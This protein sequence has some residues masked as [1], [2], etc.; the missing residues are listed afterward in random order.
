MTIGKR[1][2]FTTKGT[3][4]DGSNKKV[5]GSLSKNDHFYLQQAFGMG[6][7]PGSG[8]G[9]VEATGGTMN[10]YVD[11]G[12]GNV[13]RS[14]IFTS[15]GTFKVQ[16]SI[17]Q[18]DYLVVAGGAGGGEGGGG[19]G[20]CR[21]N[22]PGHPKA[23]PIGAFPVTPG[24]YTVTVGAGGQG[25]KSQPGGTSPANPTA[26]WRGGDGGTSEFYRVGTSY[27]N[28]NFIRAVGGG[29]GAGWGQS[30][31]AASGGSG[32]G[33]TSQPSPSPI[34][35]GAGNTPTDPNHPQPQGNNG[36]GNPTTSGGPA[37]A[38][39]GWNAVGGGG[40]N[41]PGEGGD[42]LQCLI[43]GGPGNT[44]ALGAGSPT[45]PDVR[46]GYQFFGGGGA[47]G[48]PARKAGGAGGGGRGASPGMNGED[49]VQ[50]SGGG[51]GGHWSGDYFGG[52]GGSGCVV[53]RYQIAGSA[54]YAKATGGAISWWKNPSSPTEY[55]VVHSFFNSG[56]FSTPGSFNETCEYVIVG[57]GGGGGVAALGDRGGGGGGAGGYRTG[58]TPVGSSLNLTVTIGGGGGQT[59]AV[60]ST[61]GNPRQG[62]EGRPGGDSS[63]NWP[64]GTI[65]CP[66]GGG[67]GGGYGAQN[68]FQGA[69]GGGGRNSGLGGAASPNSDPDRFGYPGGPSAVKGGGGGGA[70]SAGR[71]SGSDPNRAA[72]GL[73]VQIPATFRND[74][75]EYQLGPGPNSEYFWVAGGGG[76]GADG[77]GGIGEDN[78]EPSG[79]YAGGGLGGTDPTD[80][81]NRDPNWQLQSGW[82]GTGGGGGGGGMGPT[83]IQGGPAG[84]GGSGIVLIAYPK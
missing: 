78:P 44:V 71:P 39:G 16:G 76:G 26:G 54:G 82:A 52:R 38:G 53:V 33:C 48:S 49:G 28:V 36:G 30:P 66:G 61:P 62:G 13:Y 27:P 74:N 67:G 80:Y 47:G 55:T 9:G 51:G 4:G 20:G 57:G 46:G 63:V 43:A 70:G 2:G 73:G 59:R 21:T 69:S 23:S 72:G 42:G 81:M 64:A 19:A 5:G 6:F 7:D 77:R 40:G 65:T 12:P 10:E 34:S 60:N 58:T 56:V 68:G 50:T 45:N 41:G 14:H 24:N 32:G 1:K 3:G 29:G 8:I 31:Q 11:P 37:G 75:D 83:T 35:G 17:S 79:P 18:V 15:S 22:L 84:G 25:A